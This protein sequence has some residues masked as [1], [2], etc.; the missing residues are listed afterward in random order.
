MG[1]TSFAMDAAEAAARFGGAAVLVVSLEMDHDALSLRRIAAASGVN[2]YA[3]QTGDVDGMA[4]SRVTRAAGPLMKLPIWY[5]DTSPRL[6]TILGVI[7]SWAADPDAAGGFDRRLVVVDYA[8][9]VDYESAR[10]SS[11]REQDVSHIS[12][13]LKAV[14]R[15]IGASLLC[16]SQL[17]RDLEK[18]GNKRPM[19]SDL[20]ESGSLEQDADVIAFIYRDEVYN[21]ASADKGTAEIIVAKQRNGPIGTVRLGWDAPRTRFVELSQ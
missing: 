21:D 19:L 13:S 12:R 1:K 14:Q 11:N 15:E 7:R 10:R 5:H 8:G 3:L 18:R 20:R 9:L 6:D 17:N 2:G 4:I 16:L